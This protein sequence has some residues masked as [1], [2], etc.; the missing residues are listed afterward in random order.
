[1][2][3]AGNRKKRI[4]YLLIVMM[5]LVTLAGI[6]ACRGFFG[7]PPI[8]VL[9]I[10]RQPANDNEPPV[11]IVCN[12]SG[13]TDPDGT[14]KSYDLNF[15]DGS[16]HATGTDVTTATAITHTYM[17]AGTYTVTLKVTDNDG[18]VGMTTQTITIGPVML[19]FTR[20]NA[21][22][23]KYDI[24]RMHADGTNQMAVVSSATSNSFFPNLLRGTRDKIAYAS[25]AGGQWNIWKIAV[26]GG[27]GTQLTTQTAS[28]QIEPSWSH[29]GTL[30][31]YASNKAQTPSAATWAIWTM[32]A[33]DG[34]NQMKII[35]QT[36]S[37][38]IA[39]AYSPV[40]NDIVFV[41]GKVPVTGGSA[42]WIG[43]WNS[44][45]HTYTASKL[46]D[47]PGHDGDAGGAGIVS[48]LGLHLPGGVG[49]STP[50][51]SP[52]GTK[53]AFSAASST[54]TINIY[55]LDPYASNPAATVQSL[56]DYVN[57]LLTA[58]GKPTVTGITPPSVQNKFCPY[59]FEDNSGLAFVGED[60]TGHYNLYKVSFATGGVTPLTT[61]G[62]N[63]T[64]AS[65][66]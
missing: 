30:I 13:S 15:G 59:W 14:I 58:A 22:S 61:T 12:I 27:A 6:S 21:G 29:D 57:S 36:P 2:P 23:G 52:D 47:G 62:N 25:D 18:R 34:S 31:A 60:S 42:L 50:A 11:K 49:I 3:A 46:Y 32:N 5:A 7:Q 35:D 28:Q 64:P 40:N 56:L 39:P 10:H 33:N 48:T 55:V 44:V 19:T 51:W 43:K 24:Y 53:I 1:M 37:W 54:G 63:L 17:K 38:A 41:S 26:T 4:K 66:R 20:K 8:A 65:T 16:V 9:V 45:T